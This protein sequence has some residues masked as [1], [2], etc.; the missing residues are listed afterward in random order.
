MYIFPLQY[1]RYG[2]EEVAAKP[3]FSVDVDHRVCTVNY[4]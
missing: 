3:V 2:G 1:L 4:I